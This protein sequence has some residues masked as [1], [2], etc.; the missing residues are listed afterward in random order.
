MEEIIYKNNEINYTKF[1]LEKFKL[2]YLYY[3]LLVIKLEKLI[4]LENLPDYFYDF[5]K[6][7][8]LTIKNCSNLIIDDKINKL[9]NLEK[10]YITN[11]KSISNEIF[12]LVELKSLK[13]ANS[14]ISNDICKLHKLKKLKIIIN[15]IN[16]INEAIY[17]LS[18]LNF[19]TLISNDPKIYFEIK[20]IIDFNLLKINFKIPKYIELNNNLIYTYN[21]YSKNTYSYNDR[22]DDDSDDDSDDEIIFIKQTKRDIIY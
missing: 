1:T 3:D 17:I 16:L 5:I 11:I 15:I 13:I 4:D 14:F 6:L 21:F 9:I 2:R 22:S 20:Q 10:L 18:K 8:S 7:K 12:S 19:L